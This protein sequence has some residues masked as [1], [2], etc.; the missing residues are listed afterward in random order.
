[1]QGVHS[2]ASGISSDLEDFDRALFGSTFER[3]DI[4]RQILE[5]GF[6]A[7][8]EF[9]RQIRKEA[10]PTYAGVLAFL[11]VGLQ[12]VA[13]PV[14]YLH[15]RSSARLPSAVLNLRQRMYDVQS[16]RIMADDPKVTDLFT[17]LTAAHPDSDQGNTPS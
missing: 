8:G 3:I 2:N 10:A 11:N 17:Q 14:L 16:N 12:H 7:N 15:P 5:T 13:D 9:T 4:G 1:V 6:I